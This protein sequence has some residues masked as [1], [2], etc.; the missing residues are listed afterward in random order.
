MASPF[1][2]LVVLNVGIVLAEPIR[3]SESP[4]VNPN[5]GVKLNVMFVLCGNELMVQFVIQRPFAL[6]MITLAPV[7]SPFVCSTLIDVPAGEFV[8]TT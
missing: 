7:V 3:Y 5:A 8:P 1:N 4:F 2:A 6:W